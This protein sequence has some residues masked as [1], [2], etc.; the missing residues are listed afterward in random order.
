MKTVRVLNAAFQ[1]SN[2]RCVTVSAATTCVPRRVIQCFLLP[3]FIKKRN[4]DF[5]SS[6][7]RKLAWN[8]MSI[9]VAVHRVAYSYSV[10]HLLVISPQ[11][12]ASLRTPLYHWRPFLGKVASEFAPQPKHYAL[13][14]NRSMK[15]ILLEKGGNHVTLLCLSG[16]PLIFYYCLYDN[17]DYCL[18][19]DSSTTLMF[20]SSSFSCPSTRGS[21]VGPILGCF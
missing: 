12:R 18:C 7:S 14:T 15:E 17:S 16:N 1:G 19:N 13:V 20:E 21:G 6:N 5:L 10:P 3:K 8:L 11:S 4:G 9:C 2:P